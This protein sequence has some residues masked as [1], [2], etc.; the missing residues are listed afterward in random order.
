[1]PYAVVAREC[2]SNTAAPTSNSKYILPTDFIY[3]MITKIQND[4]VKEDQIRIANEK[5]K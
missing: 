4:M 3:R 1:M 2:Y 5:D